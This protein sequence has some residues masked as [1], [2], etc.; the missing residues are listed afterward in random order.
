MQAVVQDLKQ[1]E[2]D[3]DEDAAM[4]ADLV[5]SCPSKQKREEAREQLLEDLGGA[6]LTLLGQGQEALTSLQSIAQDYQMEEEQAKEEVLEG[7]YRVLAKLVAL[8][9]ARGI[10]LQHI[11]DLRGLKLTEEVEEE[12]RGK[13]TI[14]DRS[15]IVDQNVP[16][17]R[18]FQSNMV[19]GLGC[20]C[21]S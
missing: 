17:T 11:T 15:W 18:F 10:L 6:Y 8:P 14:S 9:E 19:A 16:P 3:G 2:G 4:W 5:S 1:G 7:L 12:P 20:R 21:S 13:T